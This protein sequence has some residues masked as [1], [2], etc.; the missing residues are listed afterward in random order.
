MSAH[1]ALSTTSIQRTRAIARPHTSRSR[2]IE[3]RASGR[4]SA[5][6]YRTS[7]S[8]S[9]R[10]RPDPAPKRRL[11]HS[12]RRAATSGSRIVLHRHRRWAEKSSID[13]S[14]CGALARRDGDEPSS[15]SPTRGLRRRI[16]SAVARKV[17][18]SAHQQRA[19]HCSELAIALCDKGQDRDRACVRCCACDA[20]HHD[21]F[22]RTTTEVVAACGVQNRQV[23]DEWWPPPQGPRRACRSPMCKL[24]NARNRQK[25]KRRVT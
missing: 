22:V 6:D 19:D 16:P 3:P 17:K 13:V 14:T 2:A 10:E 20:A 12:W 25:E 11:P 15:L 9:R 7:L 18:A 24:R 4:A 23:G 1:H 8:A 5:P 21:G